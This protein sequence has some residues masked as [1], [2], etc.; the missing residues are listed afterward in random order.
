MK[1]KDEILSSR[2]VRPIAHRLVHPSLWHMNRRSVS[3]ALAIGLLSAFLFPIG[4]FVCAALLA[5]PTRANVSVAA[6]ATLVT[7]PLT[8]PPI[9]YAAYRIGTWAGLD[10]I[11]SAPL[12]LFASLAIGMLCMGIA[13]ATSGYLISRLYF[14]IR[15]VRRWSVR[16]A[17]SRNAPS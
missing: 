12:R 6:A 13:L 5:I 11:E 9:Y 17:A 7:N 15:L 1:T 3:K 4:Q 10:A 16:S 2:W 14:R 8:F